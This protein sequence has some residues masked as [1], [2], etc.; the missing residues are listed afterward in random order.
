M[1][2]GQSPEAPFP[3]YRSAAFRAGLPPPQRVMWHLPR[4]TYG[5]VSAERG[6][7]DAER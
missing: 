7:D 5:R 2:E 4:A 6:E 1:L 3:T